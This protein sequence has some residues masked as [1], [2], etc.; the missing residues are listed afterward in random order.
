MATVSVART[1]IQNA[2]KALLVATTGVENVYTNFR[3]PKSLKDLIDY[4]NQ[5][6]QKAL[7]TW[8]IRRMQSTPNTSQSMLGQIPL[9]AVWYHH[10]FHVELFYA[11]KQDESEAEFQD[12][13]DA[14]L[15]KFGDQRTLGAWNTF[16]PLG[17]LG[18][19]ETSLNGVYGHQATFSVTVIDPQ[20]NLTFS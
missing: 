9:H 13:I 7:Q 11:Y 19:K 17:L 1:A 18:V 14:V 15:N 16:A 12:L 20:E 6:N 4:Y 10:L 3:Q 5:S 2:I 8:L